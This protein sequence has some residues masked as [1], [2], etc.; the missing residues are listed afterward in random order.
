VINN[1]SVSD[2]FRVPH[3]DGPQLLDDGFGKKKK[4]KT[5]VTKM[6]D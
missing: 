3:I 4:E 1:S 5:A 2:P 6:N